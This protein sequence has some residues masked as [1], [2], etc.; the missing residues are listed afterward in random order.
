[1]PFGEV[2]RSTGR[3]CTW[4]CWSGS[5]PRARAARW[6]CW[7][8]WRC[9]RL[10]PRPRCCRRR[11]PPAT[12]SRSR[13][14]PT[15]CR[16]L[17]APTRRA[18]P[19]LRCAKRVPGC[20]NNIIVCR[21]RGATEQLCSGSA[22]PRLMLRTHSATRSLTSEGR[23]DD[24]LTVRVCSGYP[25]SQVCLHGPDTCSLLCK[26]W[27]VHLRKLVTYCAGGPVDADAGGGRA[28]VGAL[29]AARARPAAA[30]GRAL[31]R[32]ASGPTHST[33]MCPMRIC[34]RCGAKH[35]LLLPITR[36]ECARGGHCARY[37]CT[38][39]LLLRPGLPQT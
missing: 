19:F 29:G 18:A 25:V 38:E 14:R 23:R 22:T 17:R 30:R 7:A 5:R 8:A 6:S 4:R 16:L 24:T 28:G 9:R 36:R 32:R 27:A 33:A 15:R 11:R 12:A 35:A 13:T 26:T 2:K 39:H 1:M 21:S 37:G 31:A 20:C 34:P 10:W 3:R